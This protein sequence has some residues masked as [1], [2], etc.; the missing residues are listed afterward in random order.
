MDST[1]DNSP[2][3]PP[4][5]YFNVTTKRRRNPVLNNNVLQEPPSKRHK[6]ISA[7]ENRANI[8]S[9][10]QSPSWE[11]VVPKQHDFNVEIIKNGTIADTVRLNKYNKG[12]FIIGRD[13][14]LADIVAKN[15]SISRQHCVL[16]HKN[17]GQWYLYDFGSTHG[18]RLNNKKIE[19]HKYIPIFI[20]NMF[21]LGTSNRMYMFNGPQ[22]FEP[23]QLQEMT[24]LNQ[25]NKNKNKN[26]DENSDKNKR[27]KSFRSDVEFALNTNKNN[28]G[29]FGFGFGFGGEEEEREIEFSG[30]LDEYGIDQKW[31]SI[32]SKTN[33]KIEFSYC[34]FFVVFF[35]LL[36][37]YSH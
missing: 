37:R 1:I 14:L 33:S 35:C 20:G 17:N 3:P 10:Y 28:S 21:Q 26:K 16:Q 29:G 11:T 6:A 27:S 8:S 31:L 2:S 36:T 7:I 34:F 30:E 9:I 32:V 13:G 22:E 4:A 5:K 19:S 23:Q 25:N 12:H 15:E 18:T 24:N